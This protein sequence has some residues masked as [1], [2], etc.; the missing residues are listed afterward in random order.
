MLPPLLQRQ[1]GLAVVALTLLLG[2]GEQALGT[3]RFPAS[4]SYTAQAN[5]AGPGSQDTVSLT[6]ELVDCGGPK[7]VLGP[8]CELGG[9]WSEG[10]QVATTGWS[11]G[12]RSGTLTV[13]AGQTCLMPL[14]GGTA[15]EVAVT[16]GTVKVDA[17]HL[18]DVSLAGEVASGTQKGRAVTFAFTAPAEGPPKPCR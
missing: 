10:A 13:S 3:S 6:A 17:A 16:T 4:A 14:G 2:C 18:A 12:Y 11:S 9:T 5:E 15:E 8:G 7:L 1:V